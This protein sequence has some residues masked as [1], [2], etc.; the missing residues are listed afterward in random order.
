VTYSIVEYAQETSF[1]RISPFAGCCSAAK[2]SEVGRV[3][4]LRYSQTDSSHA[5]ASI[6]DSTLNETPQSPPPSASQKVTDRK[7]PELEQLIKPSLRHPITPISETQGMVNE[8]EYEAGG[9]I[10]ARSNLSGHIALKS[11]TSPR[12]LPKGKEVRVWV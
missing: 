9:Q 6:V 11:K 1:T 12:N 2:T 3:E 7:S 10:S 5:E 4:D 8:I